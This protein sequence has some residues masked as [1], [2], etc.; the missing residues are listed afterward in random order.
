MPD[1]DDIR[2]PAFERAPPGIKRL[3]LICLAV[4]LLGGLPFVWSVLP[5]GEGAALWLRAKLGAT[6]RALFLADALGERE[7]ETAFHSTAVQVEGTRDLVLVR[8]TQREVFERTD[9]VRALWNQLRLPDVVVRITAVVEYAYAVSLREGWRFEAAEG[10]EGAERAKGLEV[11][12]PALTPLPPRV[13][14]ATLR[15]EVVDGSL[16]RDERGATD[17]LQRAIPRLAEAR[18]R[19]AIGVVRE[20]ARVE[21][22]GFVREWIMKRYADAPEYRSLSLRFADEQGGKF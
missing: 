10:A 9:R 7:V 15:N 17:R 6:G 18:A 8:M 21:A 22:E 2:D 1:P 4:T 3:V 5:L 11:T 13:D 14:L 20:S 19:E 16:F 12:A